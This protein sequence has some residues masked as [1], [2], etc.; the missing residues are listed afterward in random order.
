MSNQSFR[1]FRLVV[2]ALTMACTKYTVAPDAGDA[3]DSGAKADRPNTPPD[4]GPPSEAGLDQAGDKPSDVISGG[5]A[6][7]T[8]AE[9]CGDQ[10]VVCPVPMNAD[11]ATCDGKACGVAC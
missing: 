8:R 7:P 5:C 6:D 3:G 9:S 4:T 1:F 10:C 2:V 11:H